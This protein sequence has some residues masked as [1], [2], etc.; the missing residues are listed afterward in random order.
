MYEWACVFVYFCISSDR[1][2]LCHCAPLL[3]LTPPKQFLSDNQMLHYVTM[4]MKIVWIQEKT[5]LDWFYQLLLRPHL[6]LLRGQTVLSPL[7]WI[8]NTS[9]LVSHPL[10]QDIFGM[11]TGKRSFNCQPPSYQHQHLFVKARKKRRQY[12]SQVAILCVNPW[13][14]QR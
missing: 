12:T 10:D 14:L 7:G 8:L 5:I 1:R 6:C 11:N 4:M 13:K 2:S 3:E 9:E